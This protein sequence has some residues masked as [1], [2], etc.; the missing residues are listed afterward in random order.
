MFEVDSAKSKTTTGFTSIPECL[1]QRSIQSSDGWNQPEN[2]TAQIMGLSSVAPA[3][4]G[5]E[6]ES[7][8]CTEPRLP[9]P[10]NISANGSS[11]DFSATPDWDETVLPAKSTSVQ[12]VQGTNDLLE[13]QILTREGTD[14]A[15]IS[16]WLTRTQP[17]SASMT[18]FE[19]M[20]ATQDYYIT[21]SYMNSWETECIPTLHTVFL[22]L[23]SFRDQSCVL[24]VAMK[25][26]AACQLSRRSFREQKTGDWRLPLP[27]TM[28]DFDHEAL[29]HQ[30][31][32]AAMRTIRQ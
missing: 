7:I 1:P 5:Q 32:G 9:S 17:S 13:P 12:L 16:L 25:A 8:S 14:A 18:L 11:E 30:F 24:Q 31:Y 3:S 29:A 2:P 19:T 15:P 23:Q 27:R 20:P 22:R 26:L 10:T 6:D 4:G 28:P 21:T